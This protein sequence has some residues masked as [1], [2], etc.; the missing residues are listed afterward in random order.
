MLF[1]RTDY[2]TWQRGQGYVYSFKWGCVGAN[3]ADKNN[4]TLQL[5]K[6]VWGQPAIPLVELAMY[7]VKQQK[8]PPLYSTNVYNSFPHKGTLDLKFPTS[9]KAL[10]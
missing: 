7:A 9:H 2:A 4:M 10:T 8:L 5:S 1:A 6:H 3:K